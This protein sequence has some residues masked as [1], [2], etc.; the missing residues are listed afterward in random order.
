MKNHLFLLLFLSSSALAQVSHATFYSK[1]GYLFTI[2]L[3]GKKMNEEPQ[4][5]VR[6]INLSQ[7]YY[8]C[9]AVFEDPALAPAERKMLQLT[10]AHGNRVD[11]T[12]VVEHSKKG[13]M[14]IGWKSQS[15][16]PR[17]I[18]EVVT[19]T[20]VVV[21]NGG[22]QQEVVRTTTTRTVESNSEGVSMSF[23]GIGGR[24]NIN[25][26]YS[27]PVVEEVTTTTTTVAASPAANTASLPCG[28]TILGNQDYEMA[29]KSVSLRSSEDGKLTAAKQ[30]VSSNCFT[31]DQARRMV[32]LLSTE[33]A[34]LDLAIYAYPYVLDKGSYFKMNGVFAKE[35][36]IDVMNKAILK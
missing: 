30:I 17:Y 7:P 15:E 8:S 18:E 34:R 22:A 26:G 14:K 27:E 3:N 23:G 33:E 29:L 5:E 25:T 24:V 35:E 2:Y 16:Y 31:T 11:V 20:V 21:N 32:E 13:D 19:P 12:F 36:S 28:G 1:E 6:L 10:D 4:T 9:K